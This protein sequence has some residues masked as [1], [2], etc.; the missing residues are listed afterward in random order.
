MT[1]DRC[2][3]FPSVEF[4]RGSINK[5][6]KRSELPVVLDCT[7]IYGADFSA[8]RIICQLI[9]DFEQRSQKLLFFNLKPSVVQVF[10]GV[11]SDIVNFY[12]IKEL[13]SELTMSKIAYV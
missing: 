9:T 6:G 12:D 13:E 1:P 4:V 2:L 3:I 5:E 10:E 8:A 11:A 7:F